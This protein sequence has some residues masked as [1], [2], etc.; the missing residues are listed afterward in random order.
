M[1]SSKKNMLAG[2]DRS[3]QRYVV[4]QESTISDVNPNAK[5]GMTRPSPVSARKSVSVIDV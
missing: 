1:M 2:L 3:Y 5:G 4:A